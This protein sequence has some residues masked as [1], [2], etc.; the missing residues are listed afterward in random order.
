M[1]LASQQV[2][3]TVFT[4]ITILDMNICKSIFVLANLYLSFPFQGEHLATMLK[5]DLRDGD[6]SYAVDIRDDAVVVSFY[7][8]LM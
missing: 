2:I 7:T 1:L 4:S 3:F 5:L 6:T 8:I